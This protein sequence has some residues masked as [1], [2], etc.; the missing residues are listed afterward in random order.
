MILLLDTH[1]F[2][3]YNSGDKQLPFAFQGAI[4][5]PAN[6]VYLSAASIWEAI[7]KH[8][9]GKLPMPA[10]PATYLPVQRA[11]HHITSLAIEEAAL[12]RLAGLPLLHRDPFDRI[13]IAQ[14][15]HHGLT[16]VS[17][18]PDVRAYSVPLLEIA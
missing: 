10:P 13:I 18:D 8:A 9:I 12:E 15:L 6:L 16:L 14:T 7:V 11:A 5:D 1:I 17:I 2:L 3:W 4:R